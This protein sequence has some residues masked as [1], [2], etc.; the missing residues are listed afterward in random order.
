MVF[1]FCIDTLT[2]KTQSQSVKVEYK[3]K[4]CKHTSHCRLIFLTVNCT[5]MEVQEWKWNIGVPLQDGRTSWTVQLCACSYP[6][7]FNSLQSTH[8]NGHAWGDNKETTNAVLKTFD[9]R[10]QNVRYGC[11]INQHPII[12]DVVLGNVTVKIKSWLDSC[13]NLLFGGNH[14]ITIQ[15]QT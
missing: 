15:F 13:D 7:V 11:T 12:I 6:V 2:L 1:L 8:A 3:T 4:A 10:S 9:K 5:D 14:Q